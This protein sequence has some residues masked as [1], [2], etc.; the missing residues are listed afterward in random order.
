MK[1]WAFSDRLRNYVFSLKHHNFF[2]IFRAEMLKISRNILRV[3][4]WERSNLSLCE[5]IFA[6]HQDYFKIYCGKVGLYSWKI[7]EYGHCVALL[8]WSPSQMLDWSSLK[9]FQQSSRRVNNASK[10]LDAE[11]IASIIFGAEIFIP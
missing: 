2:N 7:H 10:K 11:I 3:K 9:L 5:T 8:L 4:Y 6:I 1:P